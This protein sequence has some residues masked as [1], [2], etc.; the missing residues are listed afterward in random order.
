MVKRVEKITGAVKRL[1][2]HYETHQIS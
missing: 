1:F 2:G